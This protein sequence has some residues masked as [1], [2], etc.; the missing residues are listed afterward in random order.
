[1]KGLLGLLLCVGAVVVGLYVSFWVC[2]IGGIVG[3][4]DSV[5]AT[6][7]MAHKLAWS[8]LKMIFFA[9]AGWAALFLLAIPGRKLIKSQLKHLKSLKKS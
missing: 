6:P 9:P 5:K 4:I 2:L 7:V 1:M 8:I 3:I